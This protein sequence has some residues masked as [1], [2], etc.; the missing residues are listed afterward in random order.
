MGCDGG[1]GLY[2]GCLQ[3]QPGACSDWVSV[4]KVTASVTVQTVN[5]KS[6]RKGG[7]WGKMGP[8][9]GRSVVESLESNESLTSSRVMNLNPNQPR[10]H[11]SES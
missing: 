5:Q 6:V 8:K 1:Y 11:E 10:S 7:K 4:D 2:V 9:M 3:Y